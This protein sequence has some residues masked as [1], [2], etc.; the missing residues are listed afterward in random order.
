MKIEISIANRVNFTKFG[1]AE[2]TVYE[3]I[4]IIRTGDLLLHD[5][6]I[7]AYRLR[8]ITQAI[9]NE[10]DPTKQNELKARCIPVATFNGIW[11][12]MKICNYSSVTA[13]DFDHIATDEQFNLAVAKLMGTPFVL[14]VFRTFKQRRLKA[15]VLHDNDKPESH[16]E[17]YQQL[18]D[19]FA[20]YGIDTCGKDLS[21]KTYLPWDDKIWVNPNCVPFHF[22]PS[23]APAKTIPASKKPSGKT[24]SPQSIINILNSSW[25]KH[26]PEYWERGCRANSVFK[27]ACQFCC[28]G[29]PQEMAEDYFLNGG[30]L[31]DDFTEDEILKHV[32]GA[33]ACNK[34]QFGSK[35]FV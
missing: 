4:D 5:P 31:A 3:I 13:L 28:Y 30:W 35:D 1:L 9:R 14:A 34:G 29:V 11:D 6:E 15:L 2:K 26:H 7:G 25:Q 23:P 22:V 24:K 21:R 32:K 27:C 33:Y 12:G 8:D 20:G 10:T 17:M 19:L 18:I 16:Q